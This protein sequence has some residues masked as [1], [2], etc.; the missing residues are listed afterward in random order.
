MHSFMQHKLNNSKPSNK[1]I[2]SA[3]K[4]NNL[5]HDDTAQ[6]ISARQC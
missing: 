4:T 1:Q 2:Y 3:G 6:G 5:I